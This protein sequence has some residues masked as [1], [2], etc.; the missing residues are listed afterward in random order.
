MKTEQEYK[1]ERLEEEVDFLQS[2]VT[3]YQ[4][5]VRS[6][7][8]STTTLCL[9]CLDIITSEF[10]PESQQQVDKHNTISYDREI[11][12]LEVFKEETDGVYSSAGMKYVLESF[13]KVL[14][15]DDVLAPKFSKRLINKLKQ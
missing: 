3:D 5:I 15:G 4:S 6:K 14:K 12:A 10:T 13:I 7:E 8:R 2:M 9:G 11:T 1:I